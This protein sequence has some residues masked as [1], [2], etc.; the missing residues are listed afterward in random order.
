MLTPGDSTDIGFG[1][2]WRR[3]SLQLTRGEFGAT[4]FNTFNNYHAYYA[5]KDKGF[6]ALAG[7]NL[8]GGLHM[9]SGVPFSKFG[10]HP[11]YLNAGEVPIGGRGS[12][13]RSPFFTQLDLHADYPW[14]ISERMKL[15]FIADFF[16]VF[17]RKTLRLI[18]ENFESQAGV[19]NV[20]FNKPLNFHT[21]FNM[22]LGMRLEF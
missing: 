4:A 17:N 11:A 1:A 19:L 20:D 2:G 15:G 18:N 14:Q 8:G 3:V 21:P 9:E 16:N 6:G 12:L 13:G 7:L 5:Q 10:A 22:R